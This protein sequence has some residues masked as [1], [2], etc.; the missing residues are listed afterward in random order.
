MRGLNGM[1][2]YTNREAQHTLDN[3]LRACVD[4]LQVT[5]HS[6]TVEQLITDILGLENEEFSGF[7]KGKYGY[8]G[9][10]HFGNIGIYFNGNED[11]GIH[12]ELSGQGCREYE[13]L[14]LY[15]WKQLFQILIDH[16]ANF[17]RLDVAIDDFKGYFNIKGLV[18]KIKNRELISKFKNA[19]RIEN[20]DIETGESKGN[21]I[22]YGG[23]SSRIQIRMY[24]KDHERTMKGFDLE[25]DLTAWNRTEIQARNERAQKI[26]GLIAE[27]EDNEMEIGKVVSGILKYYMRFV[28]K[29]EDEN[30]SRWKTAP[31]WLK[32]IGDVEALKLTEVAPDRTV[33]KTVNWIDKQVSPS[34]AILFEAF[35]GDMEL[36]KH[37]IVDGSKRLKEQD[38]AMIE[39]FKA[40]QLEID[41][42][43]ND[44]KTYSNDFEDKQTEGTVSLQNH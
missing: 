31:F 15:T 44:K 5:L 30:R 13:A 41:N 25:E 36:L 1:P 39:R 2:P 3:D 28:V 18:R 27:R 8:K 12:L 11:M 20:I 34:L 16:E 33:E 23:A 4:W 17:T 21:T 29:G 32:F 9:S 6:V 42:L 40:E 10:L 7:R 24:E 22:Y 35:E 37:F 14:E 38:Y 19:I 26:A 43:L